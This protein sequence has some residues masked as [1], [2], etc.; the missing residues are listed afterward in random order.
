M[1]SN[2]SVF[3]MTGKGKKQ[4]IRKV[5]FQL[6]LEILQSH[7]NQIVAGSL[8]HDECK[9]TITKVGRRAWNMEI[10]VCCGAESRM[11]SVLGV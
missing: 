9:C 3:E 8:F 11:S 4:S 7:D 6:V 5:S 10:P 1:E 2:S